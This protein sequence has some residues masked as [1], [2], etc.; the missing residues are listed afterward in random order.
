MIQRHTHGS[1]PA[2]WVFHV[3]RVGCLWLA[4]PVDCLRG[5]PSPYDW[6]AGDTVQMVQALALANRGNSSEAIRLA[7]PLYR[8]APHHRERLPVASI[9][10]PGLFPLPDDLTDEWSVAQVL[11]C[12]FK[13]DG[14]RTKSLA[15]AAATFFREHGM[16]LRHDSVTVAN[17]ALVMR[18]SGKEFPIAV[19]VNDLWVD[20]SLDPLLREQCLFVALAQLAPHLGFEVETAK[21][22]T[23]I[24][25]RR[26]QAPTRLLFVEGK[27]EVRAQGVESFTLE[28]A[29]FTLEGVLMVPAAE[30]AKLLKGEV[31]WYPEVRFMHL[32]IPK[33]PGKPAEQ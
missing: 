14:Q 7:F 25:L 24:E 6:T 17:A 12:A 1:S 11:G 4:M 8:K 28:H 21:G 30:V 18:R 3:L 20:F 27:K 32:I 19:T 9:A 31:H 23:R 26:Q 16:A 29:P 13:R 10:V 33:V 5:E 2:V 22:Q 15:L